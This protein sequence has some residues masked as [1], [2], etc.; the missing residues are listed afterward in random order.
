MPARI[1]AFGLLVLL[2]GKGLVSAQSLAEIAKQ[3]EARRKAIAQPAKVLTNEDLR[4]VAPPTPAPDQSAPVATPATPD[5][6]P[7]TEATTPKADAAPA[8]PAVSA[9]DPAK[10]EEAWRKRITDARAALERTRVLIAAMDSRING[11]WADFTARDDPAQRAV[12]SRDRQTAI[13]E[14][15]RL[16]QEEKDQ[17]KA[18]ADIEEEARQ[19]GIPP[20][21]LR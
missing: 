1:L 7:G 2:V 9:E 13:E 17:A 20:G 5:A 21:W 11:L 3:E 18:I 14:M 8:K 16:K 6:A 15:A 10:Q 12:I 4:R 19:A